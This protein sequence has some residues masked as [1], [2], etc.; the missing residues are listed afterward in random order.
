[1][2]FFGRLVAL[3]HHLLTIH[4]LHRDLPLPVYEIQAIDIIAART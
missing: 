4:L 3:Y 2:E 1:M